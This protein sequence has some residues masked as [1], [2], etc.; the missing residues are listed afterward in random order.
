MGYLHQLASFICPNKV[1]ILIMYKNYQAF[2]PWKWR[3][4]HENYEFR[5]L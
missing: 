2:L 3:K 4:L 5:A 1:D